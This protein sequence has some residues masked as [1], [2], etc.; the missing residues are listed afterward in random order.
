MGE[1]YND[2]K[3]LYY[4]GENGMLGGRDWPMHMLVNAH[5]CDRRRMGRKTLIATTFP[6]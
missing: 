1:L 6:Q 5:R 3:E 2:G 4:Y